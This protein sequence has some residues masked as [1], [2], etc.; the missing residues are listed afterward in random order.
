MAR[1]NWTNRWILMLLSGIVIQAF[2]Y[3]TIWFFRPLTGVLFSTHEY[4]GEVFLISMIALTIQIIGF[5]AIMS[6]TKNE[7]PKIYGQG[8]PF[9]HKLREEDTEEATRK[10]TSAGTN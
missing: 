7:D 3:L 8:R 10:P 6:K 1:A 5:A 2:A 4:F 9:K